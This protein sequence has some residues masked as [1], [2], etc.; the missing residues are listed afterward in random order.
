LRAEF[1]AVAVVHV[2]FELDVQIRVIALVCVAQ[3]LPQIADKFILGSSHGKDFARHYLFAM[4][5][6]YILA[7]KIHPS[8]RRLRPIAKIA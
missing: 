1:E 2:A 3:F 6:P 4:Y 8:A 7:R 5:K